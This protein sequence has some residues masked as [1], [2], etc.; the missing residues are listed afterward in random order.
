M[1]VRD[2]VR[3]SAT[4]RPLLFLAEAFFVV[5]FLVDELLEDEVFLVEEEDFLAE[6]VFEAEVFLDEAVVFA[7]DFEEAEP[8]AIERKAE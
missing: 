7:V 5:V 3:R 2:F 4:S 1:L 8:P 6:E